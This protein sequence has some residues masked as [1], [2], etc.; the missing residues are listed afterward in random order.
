MNSVFLSLLVLISFS[1]CGVDDLT[2]DSDYTTG[3]VG[4]Y[5][6]TSKIKLSDSI[7]INKKTSGPLP[8]SQIKT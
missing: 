2:I 8:I 1:S 5:P 4:T 7:V 3:L 6:M